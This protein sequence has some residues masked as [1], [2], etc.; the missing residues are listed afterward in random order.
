M[1]QT[2]TLW[3]DNAFDGE[4]PI[5]IVPQNGMCIVKPAYAALVRAAYDLSLPASASEGSHAMR[6]AARAGLL[7][8]DITDETSV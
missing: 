8:K 3:G 2:I 6:L 4:S 1:L 7:L 5:A